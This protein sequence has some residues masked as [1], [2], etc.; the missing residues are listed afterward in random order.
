MS[1][2]CFVRRRRFCKEGKG[3]IGRCFATSRTVN[4]S[5]LNTFRESSNSNGRWKSERNV[6]NKTRACTHTFGQQLRGV[7]S[8]ACLSFEATKVKTTMHTNIRDN[9]VITYIRRIPPSGYNH[10][11]C[12]SWNTRETHRIMY[13]KRTSPLR[14]GPKIGG[15]CSKQARAGSWYAYTVTAV[16]SPW[17]NKVHQIL[18]ICLVDLGKH[19]LNVYLYAL[20]WDTW[21]SKRQ[22]SLA[23]LWLVV[24]QIIQASSCWETSH[25]KLPL[26]IMY[27]P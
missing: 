8:C 13:W 23:Q 6:S 3:A 26:Y 20:E 25:V 2:R 27:L 7:N 11:V 9:E 18:H 5:V 10:T 1:T 4:T 15:S 24:Q 16:P 14:G 22:A 12:K 17:W 21:G 19:I